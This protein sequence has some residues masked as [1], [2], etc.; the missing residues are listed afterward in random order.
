MINQ[1]A[2]AGGN[3]QLLGKFLFTDFLFAFEFVSLIILLA[4]IGAIFFGK[5]YSALVR[6]P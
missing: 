3:T 2:E 6:E 1:T 5:R 4:I